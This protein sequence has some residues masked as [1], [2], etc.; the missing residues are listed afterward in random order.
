MLIIG[1]TGGLAS[2][3]NFVSSCFQRFR[4]PVF[5]ADLEVHKLLAGDQAVFKQ[6]K[7]NFPQAILNGKINRKILGE[8]VFKDPQEL[9]KLEQ[10]IHPSLRRKEDLFIKNC[11]RNRQEI[12]ILNIPLLFERG[13][14]RRCHKNIAVITKTQSQ[15]FRFRIRQK[16]KKNLANKN[17]GFDSNSE[18]RLIYKE[19]NNIT[20]HQTNNLQRAKLADFIIYNGL[21]KAFTFRQV[22]NLFITIRFNN[23]NFIAKWPQKI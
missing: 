7:S 14:Y 15:F 1:L 6:I 12:A 20:K 3:K 9:K 23:H 4:I 22:K 13:G 19:F 11:R 2:G 5:D 8:N 16:S 21:G 18:T 10:I 17:L